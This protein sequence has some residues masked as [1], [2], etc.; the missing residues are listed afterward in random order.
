MALKIISS[1]LGKITIAITVPKENYNSKK[2][3]VEN[4]VTVAI[5]FY[6]HLDPFRCYWHS[7]E[8]WEPEGCHETERLFPWQ[9]VLLYAV[10]VRGHEQLASGTDPRCM[11]RN[12]STPTNA[13]D[14]GVFGVTN[15]PSS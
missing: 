13:E 1:I 2:C 4:I 6:F 11:G 3:H 10:L 5:F 7:S 8:G 15:G 9:L 12:V 14:V